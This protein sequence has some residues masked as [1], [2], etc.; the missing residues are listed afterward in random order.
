ME[1][2]DVRARIAIFVTVGVVAVS[3]FVWIVAQAYCAIRYSKATAEAEPTSR[4]AG[5]LWLISLAGVFTGPCVALFSLVGL[6]GGLS[7]LSRDLNEPSRAAAIGTTAGSA[8]LV[9]MSV[10]VVAVLALGGLF[11]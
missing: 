5:V 7:L 8:I 9:G 6:V 11:G 2:Y 10:A 3:V 1:P 4:I